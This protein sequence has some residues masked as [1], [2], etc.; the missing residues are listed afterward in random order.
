MDDLQ[1]LLR[2]SDSSHSIHVVCTA[3][4]SDSA[5]EVIY[6][7]QLSASNAP[8]VLAFLVSIWTKLRTEEA[9]SSPGT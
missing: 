4:S 9:S 1:L 3:P 5:W 7:E 8:S 2:W 6:D